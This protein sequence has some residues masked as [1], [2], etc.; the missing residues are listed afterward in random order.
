MNQ[1]AHHAER[2]FIEE[3]VA[4]AL[5]RARRHTQLALSEG[6]EAARS[7][8][9]AVSLSVSGQPA[10]AHHPLADLAKALDLLS[11]G[12]ASEPGELRSSAVQALLEA[13]E[14]E[15]ARWEE[16]SGVDDDARGVLRAFLGLREV[17]WELGLRRNDSESKPFDVD[18]KPSQAGSTG[19]SESAAPRRAPN[20]A[21][22]TTTTRPRRVQRV[23]VQ[24]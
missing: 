2:H 16:R 13:L 10:E 18:A 1:R 11:T 21:Q 17:L 7:L 24:G 22:T 14:S 19:G 9:D 20:S 12:L 8:L 5:E 4:S 15:I 23:K 3:S 6:V